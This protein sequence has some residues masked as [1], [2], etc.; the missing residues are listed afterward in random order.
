MSGDFLGDETIAK[1]V[2]KLD[3][4]DDL[5]SDDNLRGDVQK[6]C[7]AYKNCVIGDF[8]KV[9]GE[10]LYKSVGGTV[11]A[12]SYQDYQAESQLSPSPLLT[13]D[14]GMVLFYSGLDNWAAEF[15]CD[16]ELLK[17]CNG[18]MR[19]GD[20]LTYETVQKMVTVL[21]K[22]DDGDDPRH[23]SGS[24]GSESNSIFHHRGQSA[25]ASAVLV[26]FVTVFGT[27]LREGQTV[28]SCVSIVEGSIT[29]W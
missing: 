3:K 14:F 26:D 22:E 1:M 10:V 15:H 24:K 11:T 2:Q 25:Y 12:I 6:T 20:F 7:S 21:E 5:G 19:N 29:W 18:V 9:F 4:K 27:T 23:R 17:G 8:M 13:K 16:H 28:T